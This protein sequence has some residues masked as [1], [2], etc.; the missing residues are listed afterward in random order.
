MWKTYCLCILEQSCAVWS[1]GLTAENEEDLERT[2]KTF[3]KLV[4]EEK[5]KSYSEALSTLNLETLK[6]RRKMLTL[7]FVKQSLADGKLRDL[8]PIR[9]KQH[10]MTTCRNEKYK[11]F[12][13]HTERYKNSPILTMQRL[14]NESN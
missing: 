7:R 1:S 2:Q 11:V 13:A 3:C 8:F 5:Y 6:K 10:T 9:T 14:L 4:L 12:K